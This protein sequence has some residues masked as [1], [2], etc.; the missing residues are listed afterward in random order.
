MSV[1]TRNIIQT[2]RRTPRKY[3][4][5]HRYAFDCVSIEHE[6]RAENSRPRNV[7]KE[8][9]RIRPPPSRASHSGRG[10]AHPITEER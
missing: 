8:C 9:S 2:F 6:L 5:I 10:L 1:R 3:E 7:L 4:R